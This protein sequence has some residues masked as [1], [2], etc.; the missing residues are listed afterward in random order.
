[1]Q[2]LQNAQRIIP[3]RERMSSES[4]ERLKKIV[5][6]ANRNSCA[7]R[8]ILLSAAHVAGLNFC[9]LIFYTLIFYT[10]FRVEIAH[11]V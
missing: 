5:P 1:M 10:M 11:A 4:P 3:S 2:M 8:P 7:S 9:T 6:L